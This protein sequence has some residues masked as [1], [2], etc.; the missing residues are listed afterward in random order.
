M[1]YVGVFGLKI[2]I[3]TRPR[4]LLTIHKYSVFFA[5]LGCKKRKKW[6]IWVCFRDAT[7]ISCNSCNSWFFFKIGFLMYFLAILIDFH[8][9]KLFYLMK[10][11]KQAIIFWI[12]TYFVKILPIFFRLKF[13]FFGDHLPP[14]A[15]PYA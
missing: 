11:T 4:W 5:A 6:A 14:H 13:P 1:S 10:V 9:I 15:S 2:T 8:K 12:F 3:E 7:I